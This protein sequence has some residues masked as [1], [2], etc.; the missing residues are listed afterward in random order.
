MSVALV[1]FCIGTFYVW[2]FVH[3]KASAHPERL[4][5][6][7]VDRLFQWAIAVTMVWTA[8][9]FVSE[10]FTFYYLMYLTRDKL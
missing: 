9:R 2:R 7:S 4:S 8:V 5:L 3:E 10:S 6:V 1:L